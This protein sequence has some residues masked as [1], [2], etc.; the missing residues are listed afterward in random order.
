MTSIESPASEVRETGVDLQRGY[1]QKP[2]GEVRLPAAVGP[3]GW[4]GAGLL[5]EGLARPPGRSQ[6]LSR[7]GG[8]G[9][10]CLFDILFSQQFSSVQFSRTGSDT[11]ELKRLSDRL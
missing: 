9:G 6:V 10:D 8:V 11:T 7:G 1:G 3:V 2:L 4:A 5:Q